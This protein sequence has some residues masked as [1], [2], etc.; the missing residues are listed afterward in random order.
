[1]TDKYP[2]NENITT[3][4]EFETVLGQLT[5]AAS[6]NGIDLRGAWE[7]H[8]A[9]SDDDWEVLIVELAGSD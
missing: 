3:A 2:F 8:D 6:Q 9:T 1:M 7:Y 4:D 5:L